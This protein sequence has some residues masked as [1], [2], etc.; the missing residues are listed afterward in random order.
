MLQS[1]VF[2]ATGLLAVFNDVPDTIPQLAACGNSF[3][4]PG[5]GHPWKNDIWGRAAFLNGFVQAQRMLQLLDVV[6]EL[7]AADLAHGELEHD[8]VDGD[9]GV[10]HSCL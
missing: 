1:V 9:K 6:G 2:A 4:Q 3:H 10:R 7:D 8:L 5:C